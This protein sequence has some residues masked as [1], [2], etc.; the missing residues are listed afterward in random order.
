MAESD[1]KR[2][3]F[4]VFVTINAETEF[5]EFEPIFVGPIANASRNKSKFDKNYIF[6]RKF[7]SSYKMEDLDYSSM[8]GY[9]SVNCR[10]FDEI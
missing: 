7:E 3:S 9:C 4:F 6:C 1:I 2:Y 10:H 8:E 5:R